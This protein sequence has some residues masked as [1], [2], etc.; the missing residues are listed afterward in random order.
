MPTLEKL[1]YLIK[2]MT[3]NEKR[4]FTQYTNLYSSK[5]K[6]DY[7]VLFDLISKH[8]SSNIKELRE[9]VELQNFEY[10]SIKTQYLYH[11]ILEVLTNYKKKKNKLIQLHDQFQQVLVL[12]G[13]GLLE[14]ALIL[15]RKIKK[16]AQEMENY[17]FLYQTTQKEME[18]LNLLSHGRPSPELI[19]HSLSRLQMFDVIQNMNNYQMLSYQ[20][21]TIIK[22]AKDKED[23]Y[24]K[25][26]AFQK[27]QN[28]LEH[29]EKALSKTAL[30]KYY[31]IHSVL[32]YL[33]QEYQEMLVYTQKAIDLI[34]TPIFSPNLIFNLYQNHFVAY[35][36]TPHTIIEDFS[37]HFK[38]LTQLKFKEEQY[39]AIQQTLMIGFQIEYFLRLKPPS[40]LEVEELLNQ[41]ESFYKKY[42]TYLYWVRKKLLFFD[43]MDFCITFQEYQI[44]SNWLQRLTILPQT[45]ELSNM[46]KLTLKFLQTILHYESKVPSLFESEIR[47]IN[48]FI[49]RRKIKHPFVENTQKLFQELVKKKQPASL[50]FEKYKTILTPLNTRFPDSLWQF[51]FVLKW[52]NHKA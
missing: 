13:K 35:I 31:H 3:R 5:K 19:Q 52:L 33:K 15:L 11:T 45:R 2:S 34:E 26:T 25:A 38:Q 42:S 29:P 39:I 43:I 17:P 28:L 32:C 24:Q 47:S 14:D 7:L 50:I 44:A 22:S 16:A 4:Y 12:E 49:S 21:E 36:H 9:E 27:E 46:E 48:Y 1:Y 40:L 18:V 20:I 6:Q 37:A 8:K 30:A 51:N 41:C 23:L 10:V